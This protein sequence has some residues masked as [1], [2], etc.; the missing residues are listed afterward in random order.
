MDETRWQESGIPDDEIS[1]NETDL[2]PEF[3][4]YHDV[5]CELAGSCLC[6]PF[7]QCFKE[8]TG[9]RRLF[10]HFRTRE[11]IRLYTTS[12]KDVGELAAIFGVSPRTVRRA[13]KTAENSRQSN[14]FRSEDRPVR[15][16]SNNRDQSHSRLQTRARWS[17]RDSSLRRRHTDRTTHKERR[18][19]IGI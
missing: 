1:A 18:R 15:S 4:W 2:L 11:I 10:K 19:H 12:G 3:C 16:F 14:I 9:G 6:C 8:E 5:G 17:F 7:P 13:F